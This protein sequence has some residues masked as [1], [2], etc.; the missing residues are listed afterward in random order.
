MADP[1]PVHQRRFSAFLSHASA[2]KE[3]LVDQLYDWLTTAGLNIWYDRE[4]IKGGNYV[5]RLA[6]GIED[7]RALLLVLSE[8]SVRSKW[9]R[10][11][12][13]HAKSHAL[14]VAGFR[15][16]I[17]RLGEPEVPKELA[18][19]N[20]LQV[21]HEGL[22]SDFLLDLMQRLYG[23]QSRLERGTRRDVYV[24]L[25]WAPSEQPFV[26]PPLERLNSRQLRLVGDSKDHPRFTGDM[27]IRALIE[28]CGAVLGLAPYRIGKRADP[29]NTSKYIWHELNIAQELGLPTFLVRQEN[30][31]VPRNIGERLLVELEAPDNSQLDDLASEVANEWRDPP[32]PAHAFVATSFSDL[33]RAQQICRFV[34][35]ALGVECVLGQA[36]KGLRRE[37]I[38]SRIAQVIRDAALVV[39]DVSPDEHG[40]AAD[41]TLIEVGIARGAGTPLLLM[42]GGERG[43]PAF[44]L[45]D[46]EVHHYE[47]TIEA[48]AIVHYHL[49]PY[50]R[51]I[52]NYEL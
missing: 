22:T 23:T 35:T 18:N 4:D 6:E 43:R 48:M 26:T 15:L 1:N 34:E 3:A 8:S 19:Q 16:V 50:R 37:S 20:F 46:M 52:F 28:S 51:R 40:H 11:E 5:S 14:D 29:H 47:N 49:Y 17:I 36:I 13:T 9:V 39:A 27:R 44:L 42:S 24:T 33:E 25:G 7:C 32:A 45:R 41:N 12:F 30:V 38:Q 31:T 10:E 2:D 21:P